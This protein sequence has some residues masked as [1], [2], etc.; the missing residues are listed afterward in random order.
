MTS[1]NE[2]TPVCILEAM[3]TGLPVVSTD[4][5]GIPEMVQHGI[6]G[7]LAPAKDAEK[8]SIEMIRI[9]QDE[10]FMEK[11]GVE[12]RLRAKSKFSPSQCTDGYYETC[13]T[14][15]DSNLT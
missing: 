15:F 4:V 7:Y 8:I 3:A 12:G 13:L 5:G 2:G 1:I 10:E 14:I 6:T 9:L 11:A